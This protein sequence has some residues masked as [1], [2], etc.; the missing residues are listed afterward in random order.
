[1]NELRRLGPGE[2]EEWYENLVESLQRQSLDSNVLNLK[3]VQLALK[4][5]GSEVNGIESS[6]GKTI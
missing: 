2:Q 4:E 1:M 3:T 5:L 6:T